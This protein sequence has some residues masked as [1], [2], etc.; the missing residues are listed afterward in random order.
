M[1]LSLSANNCL[2]TLRQLETFLLVA[3]LGSFRQAAERLFTTQPAVSSR[4]AALEDELGARLF[5]RAPGAVRL[6][7]KGQELL[8]YA[9]KVL[10]SAEN[11]R[12]RA[13]DRSDHTGVLRLGVSETIVH[14]LLP[15]F[16]A[17][18]HETYPNVDVDLTVD[19]TINL[20][21]ELVARS[22]DLAF[23]MGP[24]SES[25]IANHALCTFPLVWA[26]NPSLGL[27]KRRKLDASEL[28]R[29]PIITYA[30]H[31][32]PYVEIQTHL[33]ETADTPPRIFASS[34]LSAALR[35]TID[36]IG[37]GSLPEPMIRDELAGGSLQ[38]VAAAWKPADLG[39]TASYPVEP[40]NP[41]VEQA[42]LLARDVAGNP[43]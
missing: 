31:T 26:A 5:E 13:G 40:W 3:T 11:L 34:S 29:F 19:I 4:I 25:S 20:R 1:P 18:F 35:M 8:P 15:H 9:E 38:K 43:A 37:I 6:T 27:P 14:T 42:A 28:A 22:L 36:G 7:A 17:R 39:F 16:L 33:R 41:L 2:M 10:R 32:R 24:V 30:R 23:L 12:E 21:N